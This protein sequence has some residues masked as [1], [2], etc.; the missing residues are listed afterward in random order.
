M[1]QGRF[2]VLSSKSMSYLSCSK[3]S[4]YALCITG[5]PNTNDI[6]QYKQ[7]RPTWGC[8]DSLDGRAGIGK[9]TFHLA[10]FL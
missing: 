2:A 4:K 6:S 8:S 7:T 10:L 3:L 9:T 5:S 1:M